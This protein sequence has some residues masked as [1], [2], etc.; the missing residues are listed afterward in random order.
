MKIPNMSADIAICYVAK[1][2]LEVSLSPRQTADVVR[3]IWSDQA[4][5]GVE[6]PGEVLRS[7]GRLASTELSPFALAEALLEEVAPGEGT[8][9]A[10]R[11]RDLRM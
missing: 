5:N 3:R 10:R 4:R 8:A 9:L 7:V 2:V 1:M 11:L 6:M